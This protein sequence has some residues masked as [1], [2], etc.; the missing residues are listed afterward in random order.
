MRKKYIISA[1]VG[2]FIGISYLFSSGFEVLA[3]NINENQLIIKS[4][5]GEDVGIFSKKDGLWQGGKEKISE[6]LVEN[7][8]KQD[9]SIKKISLKHVNL[10]NYE[11]G[12]DIKEFDKEYKELMNNSFITIKD[13]DEEIYKSTL[14][15]AIKNDAKALKHPLILKAKEH[16]NLNLSFKLSEKASNNL[17]TLKEEFQLVAIYDKNINENEKVIN[18][19]LKNKTFF[20][21]IILKMPK[22]GQII[23]SMILILIS[24]ISLGT[25]IILIK[26][27]K[28]KKF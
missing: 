15:E 7:K 16:K 23:G 12:R 26:K 27:S 4:V 2:V 18:N 28:E 20:K 11:K 6:F 14:G 1:L 25:G 9:L 19:D 17:Q 24:I 13:R 21:D 8:G 5:N 10:S 3:S 22:T